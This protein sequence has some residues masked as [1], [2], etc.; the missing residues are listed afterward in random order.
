MK[1]FDSLGPW[2]SWCNQQNPTLPARMAGAVLS[3]PTSRPSP[4]ELFKLKACTEFIIY[5]SRRS[6]AYLAIVQY[7]T[8]PLK[9]RKLGARPTK[10]S[11]LPSI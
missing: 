1:G 10:R 11:R 5:A 8:A 7:I 9:G 2:Q 4:R 6:I 3:P